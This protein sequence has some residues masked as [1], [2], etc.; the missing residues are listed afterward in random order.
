LSGKRKGVDVI[1]PPAEVSGASAR[2]EVMRLIKKSGTSI[3]LPLQARLERRNRDVAAAERKR[4]GHNIEV[5]P[6]Q[7]QMSIAQ[8]QGQSALSIG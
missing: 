6:P 3:Y 1:V 7:I 4:W 2:P 8:F 5:M